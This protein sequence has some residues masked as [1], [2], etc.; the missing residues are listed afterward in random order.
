MA[1]F[2]RTRQ[3]QLSLTVTRQQPLANR[4]SKTPIYLTF[5]DL[6]TLTRVLGKPGPPRTITKEQC[7]S[8]EADT[9][10]PKPGALALL[11]LFAST[12]V[13]TLGHFGEKV[14]RRGS[15]SEEKEHQV[16]GHREEGEKN[17]CVA[18][19][20]FPN[21]VNPLVSGPVFRNCAYL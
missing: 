6:P 8:S 9:G 12:W 2:P 3:T 7:T 19:K 21:K 1:L 20:L 16:L 15:C 4:P 14:K 11:Q 18:G 17:H 13:P 5:Q 10:Y